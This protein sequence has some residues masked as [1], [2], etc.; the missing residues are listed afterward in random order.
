MKS[1][2]TRLT[3]LADDLKTVF[4][5]KNE[6]TAVLQRVVWSQV[7]VGIKKKNSEQLTAFHLRGIFNCRAGFQE[8][9]SEK[10]KQQ[11]FFENH[12]CC[13]ILKTVPRV[14]RHLNVCSINSSP[15]SLY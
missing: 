4:W 1:I 12:Q 14:F 3:S 11:R 2:K 15:A 8:T 6:D 10:L 5:T 7:A 9:L 13:S